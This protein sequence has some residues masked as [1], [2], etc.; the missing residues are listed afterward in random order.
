ME[1]P[2]TK[3]AL[4]EAAVSKYWKLTEQLRKLSEV[5][6]LLLFDFSDKEKP[7]SSLESRCRNVAD[8]LSALYKPQQRI[9]SLKK[10]CPD[11][12]PALCTQENPSAALEEPCPQ[13]MQTVRNRLEQSHRSMI[14]LIAG[15]AEEDLFHREPSPGDI[16]SHV[17]CVPYH[18][19]AKIIK[20]HRKK[21]RKKLL[22]AGA[23]EQNPSVSETH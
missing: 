20:A 18:Q 9:L 14:E 16:L 6:I 4:M 11:F 22:E 3:A 10:A 12:L 1:M 21:Q 2:A 19:A 5:E 23:A 17:T 7:L 15:I 13:D 8:L